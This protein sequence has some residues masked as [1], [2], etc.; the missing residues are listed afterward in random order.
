[1]KQIIPLILIL[2]LCGGAFAQTTEDYAVE[3]TATIQTAPAKISLKWKR[4][5]D[6]T[7]YTIYKKNKSAL[8]WGAVIATLSTTDSTYT[9]A[10]VIVDSAY[11]YQVV[12]D[13]H[14]GVTAWIAK[15]YIYAAVKNPAIHNRG[16]LVLMIDSTFTDS[17]RA[18]I[19]QLMKDLSGDGWQILRHDVARTLPDT[20]VKALITADYSTT[21][22]VKA[23][24]ILGHVAVPYSGDQNPDGHPDHL[25]AWPADA[26]YAYLSDTWTDVSVND[27]SAGYTANQ[28]TPGDGKWD[29]V[30]WA[31]RSEL[32][33]SRI[34]F[35][36]MPAFS[37]TEVQLMRSYLAKDHRY[38]MDSLN[39]RHRGLISDNFGA[40]SGEAFATSGWRNF[41]PLMG[42]DSFSEL[43]FIPSLNTESFQWA[44][45]CG[46]GWFT[47][48]GGIG[49]TTDFT[50]NNVNGIFTMLFGSYFGDWNVQNNFLRAPLC[51]NVPAL[52]CCWAGRPNWYFHH[53]ALG[54]NIGYSA[55]QSQN[56]DGNLYGPANIYGIHQ[57][58]HIALMGDLSLR[59]DY[60][61]PV[62]NI[63]I[64]HTVNHGANITW[65]P[66]PDAAVI[67][68]YVY[69]SDSEYDYYTKLSSLLTTTTF[70]DTVGY[71]G[72]KYY[73]VRPVKLQ[74]TPSGNYYN[75]GV[76]VGDSA[77][78]SFPP[79]YVPQETQDL[80]FSVFP[81]PAGN[82]INVGVNSAT[83][84]SATISIISITGAAYYVAAKQLHAGQNNYTLQVSDLSSGMYFV[85]INSREKVVVA[86]WLKL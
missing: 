36:D 59:T 78:V 37:A 45:G 4:L 43:P 69:R 3:L 63:I 48:A 80:T 61:K 56:N 10:G 9:D 31:S 19:H 12:A 14:S 46:P 75:L 73:Q 49:T 52:T 40:M 21:P 83:S 6:T 26:Y 29:Q 47:S 15:G 22:N 5:S 62:A 30:G 79:T 65:S 16:A 28:N 77:T 27:I 55:W 64:T 71:N 81:N 32:Q 11:E 39:I 33:V 57:W 1:M 54:E 38:K 13:H 34:D 85:K 42:I 86:K 24:L 41:A 66:S 18:D 23:L 74:S 67:G 60:I 76:G 44:Y 51:A 20:A 72:L 82:Y 84:A 25:G 53:M 7:I 8:A 58:V 17:C 2:L 35:Y 70:S 50:T 68:Y